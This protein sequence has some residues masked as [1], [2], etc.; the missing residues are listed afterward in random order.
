[1]TPSKR[2]VEE[3]AARFQ[4]RHTGPFRTVQH[5]VGPV[6]LT[7][8]YRRRQRAD[9]VE[10]NVAWHDFWTHGIIRGAVVPLFRRLHLL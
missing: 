8:R 10:M 4:R 3:R 5:E 7:V 9:I 1:M 6:S 2:S